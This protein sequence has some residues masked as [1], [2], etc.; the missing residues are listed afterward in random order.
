VEPTDVQGESLL[1]KEFQQGYLDRL[2]VIPNEFDGC[3][4]QFRQKFLNIIDPL[5]ANNNLGRSVSKGWNEKALIHFIMYCVHN[6]KEI[7]YKRFVT[8]FYRR[9]SRTAGTKVQ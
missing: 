6:Y 1:G 4:T 2:V 5:K 7:L 9:F 8:H 3:G